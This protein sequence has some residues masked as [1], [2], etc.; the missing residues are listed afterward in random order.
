MAENTEGVACGPNYMCYTS[1]S[2]INFLS[3]CDRET[4][5]NYATSLI[6][7]TMIIT[8]LTNI[9]K[10]SIIKPNFLLFISFVV[11]K[12]TSDLKYCKK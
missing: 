2:A 12:S 10:I 1:T 6:F 8:F 5:E 3:F 4:V 11:V 7:A 9:V